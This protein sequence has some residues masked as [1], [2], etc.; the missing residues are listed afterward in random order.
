MLLAIGSNERMMKFIK[1]FLRYKARVSFQKKLLEYSKGF[2]YFN[3]I[4]CEFRLF[5]VPLI[6]CLIFCE[7]EQ[8][9]EYYNHV[10]HGSF[11]Y[12]LFST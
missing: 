6:H 3:L 8:F 11:Q 1:R 5:F 12:Q 2:F 7:C 9:F 10:H 4:S